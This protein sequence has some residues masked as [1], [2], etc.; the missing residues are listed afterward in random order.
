MSRLKSEPSKWFK[1]IRTIGLSLAGIAGAILTAP[2][3]LP[4]G[5][6]TLAGY[7]AL[8]G[9]VAGVVAHTAN[10]NE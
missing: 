1:A 9:T 6:V 7:I 8:A 10:E 3:A 5:V 2:I 4:A